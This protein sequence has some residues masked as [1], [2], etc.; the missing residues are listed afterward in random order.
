MPFGGNGFTRML[1]GNPFKRNRMWTTASDIP[2]A[3]IGIP[4]GAG[5]RPLAA[6]GFTFAVHENLHCT[7]GIPPCVKRI[8]IGVIR[9]LFT[10]QRYRPC[11][12]RFTPAWIGIPLKVIGM[13]I[14]AFRNTAGR[15][16]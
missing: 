9:F 13:P 3:L 4:L 12:R 7:N 2:P 14:I 1:H 16:G 5:D 8:P 6:V 15:S 10:A 11:M